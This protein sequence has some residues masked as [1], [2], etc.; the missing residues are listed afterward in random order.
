MTLRIN[1]FSYVSSLG[2]GKLFVCKKMDSVTYC[3]IITEMILELREK[4]N[5]DNFRVIHD[6]AA[7][8][9]S[10]YTR[11]YLDEHD[12]RRYFLHI[13]PYSP[14]L[15]IIENSW[16]LLERKVRENTFLFGQT[17]GRR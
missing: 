13:P 7:F 2:V 12:L 14:D 1:F 17:R 8:S 6:N 9:Q 4:F 10:E 11:R 5:H 16:A 15:N 3:Q